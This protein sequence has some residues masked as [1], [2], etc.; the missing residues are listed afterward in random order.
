MAS[1]TFPL[2]VV[3][4][5]VD[6]V[7]R[8]LAAI[9]G[10]IS[11]FSKQASSIGAGLTVGVTAPVL[12]FF[13][14]AARQA[15]ATER[16]MHRLGDTTNA[17]T[18]E[19]AAAAKA[20]ASVPGDFDPHEGVDALTALAKAGLSLNEAMGA[21]PAITNLAIAAEADLAQ[22]A[23]A[24]A[25]VL[26]AYNLDLTETTKVTDLLFNANTKSEG[27]LSGVA[28]SLIRLA[29]LA[30]DLAIPVEQVAAA[31]LTIEKVRGEPTAV[32]R[33]S[34]AAL[35]DPSKKAAA[36]LARLKIRREDVFNSQGNLRGLTETLRVLQRQGATAQDML[37]I[38]G[39]K[40]GPGLQALLQQGS[41]G[42]A[43]SA[44]NLTQAG[45]AAAGAEK[46][47]KGAEGALWELDNAFEDLKETVARSG[48]LDNLNRAARAVLGVVKALNELDPRIVSTIVTVATFAAVLGPV[49][50][51]LGKVWG[52]LVVV[53]NV[54]T[55]LK[56]VLSGLMFVFRA[57]GLVVSLVAA[58][59]GLPVWAIV[60]IGAAIAAV[61]IWWDEWTGALKRWLS[62]FEPIRKAMEWLGINTGPSAK[63]Q[64]A[65]D[66]WLPKDK[67]ASDRFDSWLPADKNGEGAG[68]RALRRATQGGGA[69]AGQIDVR[70]LNPPQGLRATIS[71]S[72]GVDLG[73]DLGPSMLPE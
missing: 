21:L 20:A 64:A 60:A 44:A 13:T 8:P 50:W 67:Q 37:D 29:P 16:A 1:K 71:K 4:S 65:F 48:V 46:R 32:L 11:T 39:K 42:L 52:A 73:V 54:A 47:L 35:I 14:L 45:R 61:I 72:L 3:I 27:G 18:A 56:P 58:V 7:S 15:F 51:A 24:T 59:L 66:S 19:L 68:A 55:K 70:F 6:R 53:W 34:M 25:E 26:R 12:G 31:I 57:L 17:T 30:R 36:T 22:S 2:A 62:A 10:K 69:A 23:R 9:S 33:A 49:I 5:A 63:T 43:K 28:D 41:E 40:A 38:F